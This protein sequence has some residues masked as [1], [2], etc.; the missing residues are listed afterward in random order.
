MHFINGITVESQVA[1]QKQIFAH[2]TFPSMC[3]GL[4]KTLLCFDSPFAFIYLGVSV[5]KF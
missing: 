2:L 1:M 4:D 3:K 5:N